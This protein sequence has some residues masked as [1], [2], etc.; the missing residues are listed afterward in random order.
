M[1]I[2]THILD[3]TQG[4]PARGVAVTLEQ[5]HAEG[6]RQLAHAVTDEDGR[7]KP[8]LGEIPA[9]GLY[10]ICFEVADHFERLGVESF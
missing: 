3:T 6:W 7:V 10:R 4:R 8:L 1:G 2:S 5:Q 9:A